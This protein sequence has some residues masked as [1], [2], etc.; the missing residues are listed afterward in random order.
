MATNYVF[1]LIFC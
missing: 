1:T